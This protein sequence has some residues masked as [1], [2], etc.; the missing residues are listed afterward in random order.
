MWNKAASV[1]L[2]DYA[3]R[4]RAVAVRKELILFVMLMTSRPRDHSSPCV[5]VGPGRVCRH[6][7]LERVV[8]YTKYIRVSRRLVVL[9]L[10]AQHC[11]ERLIVHF[12]TSVYKMASSSKKRK[13]DFENR[14]WKN[15]FTSDFCFILSEKSLRPFCLICHEDIA[16]IKSSNI[17]R[18]F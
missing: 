5:F 1:G 16:I 7:K 15:E 14:Q 3:V 6:V 2:S 18:H 9:S 8:A 10:A 4:I 12:C 17:K 11:P 13:V